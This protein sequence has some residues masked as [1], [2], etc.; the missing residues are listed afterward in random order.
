MV[1]GTGGLDLERAHDR[2]GFESCWGSGLWALIDS[3][4]TI[5]LGSWGVNYSVIT[6]NKE[7]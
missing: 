5:R 3:A 4:Y 7:P 1:L 2:I 6:S